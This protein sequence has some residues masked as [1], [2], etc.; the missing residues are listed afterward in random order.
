VK[1]VAAFVRSILPT[2]PPQLFFLFGSLLLYISTDLRF[3]PEEWSGLVSHFGPI[4]FAQATSAEGSA[5]IAWAR[6]VWGCALLLFISGT[7]GLYLCLRPG[8]RPLRNIVL[9]VWLPAV[10][11]VGVICV[12]FSILIHNPLLKMLPDPPSRAHTVPWIGAVLS[13]LGPGLHFSVLGILCV[14]YFMIRM[15]TGR[16]SLPVS[17]NVSSTSGTKRDDEWRRIWLFV[18]FSITCAFAA[19]AVTAVALYG[20]SSLLKVPV[21]GQLARMI[22]WLQPAAGTAVVAGLAAWSVGEDRWSELRRFLTFPSLSDA[23]ATSIIVAANWSYLR[24]IMYAHDRIVWASTEFGKF[25]APRMGMYFLAPHWSLFPE[26]L[27]AA[28]F[29]E[30]I[31]RGYLQPRFIRRYGVLRGLVIL[32][33]LWAAFHFHWDFKLDFSDQQIALAFLWR[34]ALCIALGLVLGWTRLRSGSILPAAVIHGVFN[35]NVFSQFGRRPSDAVFFD[36]AF[37]ALTACLL[38]RYWPPKVEEESEASPAS[39]EPAP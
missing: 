27:P 18:W 19:F 7:A 34:P 14:S 21:N 23:P 11:A 22:D 12:R 35:I 26:L 5:L 29:E 31:Y 9:F 33:L 16:S 20:L 28:L 10:W 17:L 2:D 24:V 6:V 4:I 39:P 15:V 1:T 36:I 30:I 3:S 38:F 8:K 25:D 13:R 37:W 32:G